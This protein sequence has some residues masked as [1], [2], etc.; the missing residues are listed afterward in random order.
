MN[1]PAICFGRQDNL[2]TLTATQWLARP[3]AE[4]FPFFADA[5]NLDVITPPWLQF[6]ILTTRPIA[7]Q[8]GARIDYRLRLHGLPLCWQS[9]ITAWQPPN[10]FVDEQHRGPYRAWI[11][12]HTFEERGGGTLVCDR[13]Q[14]RVF[15]GQLVERLFVRRDLEKIFAHRHRRLGELFA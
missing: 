10:R 4:V 2:F 8:V 13:I 11:H 1:P 12:E 15:G 6:E 14:Y 5:D 9:E 7:M 3:I